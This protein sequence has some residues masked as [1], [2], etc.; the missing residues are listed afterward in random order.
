MEELGHWR[1]QAKFPYLIRE[2][3]FKPGY[4]IC[5]H[6]NFTEQELAN[7][8]ENR[9]VVQAIRPHNKYEPLLML[10]LYGFARRKGVLNTAEFIWLKVVNRKV[11][12]LCNNWGR[13]TLWVEVAGAMAHFNAE[14]AISLRLPAFQGQDLSYEQKLVEEAVIALKEILTEQGW[15]NT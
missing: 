2:R 13:R 14:T 8:W 6:L 5:T 3:K 10:A 1:W 9:A 15:I 11:F 7:L 4:Q 12:Y